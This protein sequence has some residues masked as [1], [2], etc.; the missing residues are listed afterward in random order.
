[1][2]KL[3]L[4]A[5]TIER[6]ESDAL[7]IY[8]APMNL[9]AFAILFPLRWLATPTC[10]RP[11]DLALCLRSPDSPLSSL[12]MG[13][14]N[15]RR[16]D[17]DAQSPRPAVRSRPSFPSPSVHSLT[18]CLPLFRTQLPRAP[19]P[20]STPTRIPLH[21]RDSNST[22]VELASLPRGIPWE[23]TVDSISARL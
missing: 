10:A 21:R 3:V 17:Q 19:H 1:L 7:T 13:P 5:G 18:S 14:K 12:Q 2:L 22:R 20:R 15:P 8:M 11:H 16:P 23:G 4:V 9:I 6:V